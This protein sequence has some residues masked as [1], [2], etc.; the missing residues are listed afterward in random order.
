MGLAASQCRLLSM[1]ARLSNNEF[2]QQSI[3]YSK[4][5]LA[6]NSEQINDKYLDAL[7]QTQYQI[8]T[9]YNGSDACYADI[10]YNQMTGCNTV[11][12]GK[13]YLVKD[14]KGKVLVNSKIANAYKSTNGDFNGFLNKLGYTQS[15]I[16]VTQSSASETAIHNAWDKYL[17]SVG[18]SI[19]DIDNEHILDFGYTS[20]NSS[21]GYATYDSAYATPTNGGKS[22]NLLKEDGKYYTNKSTVVAREYTDDSGIT[23]TGA[24]YQTAEQEGTEEYTLIPQVTYDEKTGKFTYTNAED[25]EVETTTLYATQNADGKVVLSEDEK[26]YLTSAQKTDS[27]GNKYYVSDSG[28]EYIVIDETKA[29]NYDG[30]TTAQRELYDYAVAIT[31]AY[32]NNSKTGTSSNL[33]YDS[34]MITYYK[35][36]FNEMRSCGYTTTDNE[37]NLKDTEWF[38]KQLQ[39]GNLVL[40]YYS[41]TDKAFVSTSL[42]DDESVREVEDTSAIAIAEQEYQTSM[43]RIENEDKRFDMQLNKLEAEHSALQTEYDAVAKVISKNVEKSFNIFNA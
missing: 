15:D 7:N 31:E 25:T 38:V 28:V 39:A 14:N 41:T 36:I 22:V 5:R 29:L 33:T 23:R 37:T 8:L 9:G 11:A 3:A 6:E 18:K 27:E 21:K 2:E 30:T 4:E 16:D 43:D 1:T 26:N 19:N 24:F 12:C 42:D 10:T 40:S 32:Y 20:S 35:N 17:V 34:D 13:Q